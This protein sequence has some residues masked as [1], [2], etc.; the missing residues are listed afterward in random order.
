[1]KA[2]IPKNEEDLIHEYILRTYLLDVLESDI[3][4]IQV[5]NFKLHEPYLNFVEF[6]LKKLRID[7]RDIK[8]EMKNLNIKVY[9]QKRVNEEFVQYDYSA[10]GYTGYNRYWDAALKMHTTKLLEKYFRGGE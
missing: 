5:A 4:T 10:H 6:V 9:N 2:P 8:I 1:M 3:E 7:L